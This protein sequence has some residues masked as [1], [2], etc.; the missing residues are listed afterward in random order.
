MS[1]GLQQ[2]MIKTNELQLIAKNC[3]NLLLHSLLLIA[4]QSC[5][6]VF[7]NFVSTGLENADRELENAL[8]S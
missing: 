4:I 7:S 5:V 2:R 8:K 1:L 6:N 3:Y